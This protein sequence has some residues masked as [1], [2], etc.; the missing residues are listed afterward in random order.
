MFSFK[1]SGL[2]CENYQLSLSL[3]TKQLIKL[4]SSNI[5]GPN[6][7]RMMPTVVHHA[8]G[9]VTGGSG[10]LAASEAGSRQGLIAACGRIVAV[11]LPGASSIDLFDSADVAELSAV[12]G[13][14]ASKM[15]FIASFPVSDIADPV[16]IQALV[17]LRGGLLA[18]AG[19][20]SRGSSAYI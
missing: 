6:S 2:A 3:F 18:I 13:A 9:G 16:A 1:F 19:V 14:G 7:V 20:C 4:S 17:F 8:V 15:R 11:A 5:A 12:L 10:T